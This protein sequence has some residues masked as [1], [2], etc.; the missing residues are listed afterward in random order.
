MEREGG[1]EGESPWVGNL[2]L[3]MVKE[4]NAL[5]GTR[6]I[7]AHLREKKNA[8]AIISRKV[9][10]KIVLQIFFRDQKGIIIVADIIVR[11]FVAYR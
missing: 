4:K 9:Q 11:D 5:S 3:A 6:N 1:R 7:R 2:L 8:G 10:M